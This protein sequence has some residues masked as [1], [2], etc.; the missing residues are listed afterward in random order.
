MYNE[1]IV[2]TVIDGITHFIT[3]YKMEILFLAALV[4][5]VF[6]VV[7]AKLNMDEQVDRNE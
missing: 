6:W 7:K 3:L 2:S 5:I 4:G 1:D